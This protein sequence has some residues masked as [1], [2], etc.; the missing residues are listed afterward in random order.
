MKKLR[1]QN[2]AAALTGRALLYTY[3]T[4]IMLFKETSEYKPAEKS[5]SKSQKPFASN[6]LKTPCYN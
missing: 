5:N 2:T 1:L 3:R 6:Q 4:Y